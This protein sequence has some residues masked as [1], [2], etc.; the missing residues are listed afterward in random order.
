M[1]VVRSLD[2]DRTFSGFGKAA[3]TEYAD[4]FINADALPLDRIKVRATNLGVL[5]LKPAQRLHIPSQEATVLITSTPALAYPAT[6]AAL[7]AAVAAVKRGGGLV[8]ID[9]NWRPVFW[10]DTEVMLVLWAVLLTF[11]DP[12][13]N[14]MFRQRS[15]SFKSMSRQPTSS[16]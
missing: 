8:V 9:V 14:T 7:R 12:P 1:L 2:G 4:C 11:R 5:W 10:E 3:T 15:K 6:A 13:Q 16:R